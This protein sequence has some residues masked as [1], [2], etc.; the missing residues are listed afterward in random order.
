MNDKL[1][2][3]ISA[4]DEA[5]STL[6]S[7]L[8]TVKNIGI[9]YLSWS[10]VS[11]AVKSVVNAAAES[12]AAWNKVE[13]SLKR[14]NYAVKGNI[15]AIKSF[16]DEMIRT[17]GIS[18]EIVAEG[19]Q[20]LIDA[21][22]SLTQSFNISRTAADLAA[23]AH[24]DYESAVQLLSRASEGYTARLA[25]YGIRVKDTLHGTAQLNDLLAQTN[26]KFG[27]AAQ[28]ELNTYTGQ[29]KLLSEQWGEFQESLGGIVI[30][31]L[32]DTATKLN[33]LI[34]TVNRLA[35]SEGITGI[36]DKTTGLATAWSMMPNIISKPFEIL[37]KGFVNIG[38]IASKEADEMF[39]MFDKVNNLVASAEATTVQS[40]VN[41][42]DS[43]K[44]SVKRD[45][46]YMNRLGEQF[47]EWNAIRTDNIIN[48][49]ERHFSHLK[50]DATALEMAI[51]DNYTG[52]YRY[53]EY[54]QM[55]QE[56][57]YENSIQHQKAALE[58]F[59]GDFSSAMADLA[60]GSS[61][62]FQK[63]H[64]D[65]MRY[66]IKACIEDMIKGFVPKFLAILGSIFDNPINDRMAARQGGDFAK[67]FADGMTGE[68][69]KINLG[70]RI[71]SAVAGELITGT[72]NVKFN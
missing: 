61:V 22:N 63:M 49:Q 18:D 10:A 64:K 71:N 67:Y 72:R 57:E 9:A 1:L 12:E 38:L 32:T 44:G 62:N 35:K 27:G 56:E 31:T 66:F 24:I 69:S 25:I 53:W 54:L 37:L 50:N 43:A 5:S 41:V 7:V 45:I 19:M 36:I 30:P 15:E 16:G 42:S 55:Q 51:K 21:G 46:D 58:R 3:T 70:K 20:R 13:A 4:K 33:I 14:H 2:M 48:E 47:S 8:G 29:I 6:N 11:S 17:T 39:A 40:I 59:E 68:L 34:D 60:M 65:F 28:S 26:A 23:G 52:T